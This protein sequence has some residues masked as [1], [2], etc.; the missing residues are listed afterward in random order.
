M[1]IENYYSLNYLHKYKHQVYFR[2]ADHVSIGDEVLVEENDKLI[3]RKVVNVS[4]L[5]MQGNNY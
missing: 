2:Y 3:P 5:L 1:S 4:G